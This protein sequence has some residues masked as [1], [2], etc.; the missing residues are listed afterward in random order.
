V[1][2]PKPLVLEALSLCRPSGRVSVA[3]AFIWA[4]ARHAGI[5]GVYTF[6]RRF[7]AA[8]LT[9]RLLGLDG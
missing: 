5:D 9:V 7:P 2:L 8:N 3:D 4:S 6:D 1:E